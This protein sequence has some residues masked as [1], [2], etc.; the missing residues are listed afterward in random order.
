MRRHRGGFVLLTALL[1]FV[2]SCS[3]NNQPAKDTGPL[4]K[5]EHPAAGVPKDR[6]QDAVV[7]ALR[8]LDAC[9]LLD[10]KGASV[11]GK[12]AAKGPHRCEISRESTGD[13]KIRVTIGA[14]YDSE[15]R[16]NDE[17]LAVGGMKAYLRQGTNSCTGQVPVSFT[18]AIEY[19][20]E[21]AAGGTCAVAKELLQHAVTRLSDQDSLRPG[22]NRP[23]A[24]WD[25]CMLLSGAIGSSDGYSF[26]VDSP[27]GV[28]GCVADKQNAKQMRLEISYERDPS[29]EHDKI[30]TI[31]GK[32]VRV[33]EQSD[34]CAYAWSVGR[35]PDADS[36]QVVDLHAP[37][38]KQGET[39]VTAAVGLLSKEPPRKSVNPQRPLTYRSDEPDAPRPGACVDHRERACQPYVEVP[40]PSGGAQILRGAEADPNVICAITREA[41]AKHLGSEFKPVTAGQECHFGEPTHTAVLKVGVDVHR[42]GRGT[43]G[44]SIKLA[45]HPAFRRTDRGRY[46]LSTL[47][48]KDENDKAAGL[49]HFSMEFRPRRG[50]DSTEPADDS[51]FGKV[52]PLVTDVL[53]K[54]FAG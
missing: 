21:Q 8:Q 13:D 17:L 40:V 54:Y 43:S 52:E 22:S 5:V 41:V 31:G 7:A 16:F 20:V 24:D 25:A 49:L 30:R 28:D 34:Y 48:A 33:Y 44:E 42:I 39:I 10:A 6:D 45:G 35:V 29:K 46:E 3:S 37:D 32:P 53:T 2:A 38:C 4:P 15:R 14:G 23:M 47:S 9:A 51:R 19:V 11:R 36:D 50:T 18:L 12:P 27:L 26:A 1:A